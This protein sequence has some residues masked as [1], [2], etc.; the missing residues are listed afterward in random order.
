M[1]HQMI[2]MIAGGQGGAIVNTS[3]FVAKNA[4][5]G[6]SAYAASKGGL[7]AMVAGL[8]VEGGP[9]GIRINNVLPGAIDTS[10][11]ARLDGAAAA[12]AVTRQTPLGRLG[13]PADVADVAVWLASDG[14]R[15]VTGQTI[16]V[17]GGLN[18]PGV[19]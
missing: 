7:D 13:Q 14:A 16:L 11:F 3:S 10:M 5:A 19:R 8:A 17:D 9:H 15:F 6:A 2:A 1:K 18:L 12:A 4:L